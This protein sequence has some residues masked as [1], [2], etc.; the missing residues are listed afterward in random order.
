MT[1]KSIII[2]Q[3]SRQS[4]KSLC[5]KLQTGIKELQERNAELVEI[6]DFMLNTCLLKKNKGLIFEEARRVVAKNME[7]KK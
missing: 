2:R 7:F 5:L 6:M 4:G 1:T 3:G